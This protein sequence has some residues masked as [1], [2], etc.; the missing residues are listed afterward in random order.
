MKINSKESMAL[1][2]LGIGLLVL[3][4]NNYDINRDGTKDDMDKGLILLVGA[5]AF[6]YLM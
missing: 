4:D 2:A 5:L 6:F 1:V 3:R